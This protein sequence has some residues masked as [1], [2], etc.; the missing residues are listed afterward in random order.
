MV[1]A[2]PVA[3]HGMVMLADL[4]TGTNHTLNDYSNRLDGADGLRRSCTAEHHNEEEERSAH[5]HE[6]EAVWVKPSKAVGP[7]VGSSLRLSGDDGSDQSRG[8]VEAAGEDSVCQHD[9]LTA[10]SLSDIKHVCMCGGCRLWMR[11]SDTS[12]KRQ[13]ATAKT[14]NRQQEPNVT[15]MVTGDEV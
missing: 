5:L 3:F 6:A 12:T 11:R 13:E 8:D 1:P 14:Q 9:C 10:R 15:Q 4:Q 2:V 7:E